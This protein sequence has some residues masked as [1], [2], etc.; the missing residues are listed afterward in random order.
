MPGA[1]SL[2]LKEYYGNK[3]NQF[4]K[5]LADL[6]EVKIPIEYR[7]KKALLHSARIALWDV[8]KIC[9]RKG[10][11]DSSIER[12]YANNIPKLLEKKKGIDLIV[13]NGRTAEKYFKDT[14]AKD[15]KI[16]YRYVP[17][18]SSAHATFTL[19]EKIA[20][21]RKVLVDMRL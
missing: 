2:R 19:R 4:W 5:I 20:L 7:D 10:S 12:A 15:V 18:T 6:L 13:L 8:L 3:T 1:T 11:S 21:W 9:H 16:P 17:S 14:V